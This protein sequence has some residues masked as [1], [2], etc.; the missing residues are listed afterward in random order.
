MSKERKD[1]IVMGC[2]SGIPKRDDE[3]VW[4]ADARLSSEGRETISWVGKHFLNRVSFRLCGFSP[5]RRAKESAEIISDGKTVDFIPL[6]ELSPMSEIAWKHLFSKEKKLR[7]AAVP[8]LL[9]NWTAKILLITEGE[10]VFGCIQN[11]AT[12]IKTGEK[13]LLVSHQPLIVCAYLNAKNLWDAKL[14]PEELPEVRPGEMIVF[15]FN[16]DN[17]LHHCRHIEIPI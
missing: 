15:S 7:Y 4:Q 17:A 2:G 10:R 8:A 12:L 11:V 13:A 6:K 5:L 14:N 3:T 16:K 1:V 9:K